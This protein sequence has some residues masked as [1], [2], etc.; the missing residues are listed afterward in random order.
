MPD[1]SYNTN[2]DTWSASATTDFFAFKGEGGMTISQSFGDVSGAI[3]KYDLEDAIVFQLTKDTINNRINNTT[4]QA[5]FTD[6][7]VSLS[8]ADIS[9]TGME[10]VGMGSRFKKIYKD[11]V[12][13][14]QDYFGIVPSAWDIPN[15]SLLFN[16]PTSTLIY[17]R[18]NEA[19]KLGELK[20]DGFKAL[21]QNS[22]TTTC[23]LRVD[24]LLKNFENAYKTN[25]FG[26]KNSTI[27][28]RR[29][30]F[31]VDDLIYFKDGITVRFD[32]NLFD[33]SSNVAIAN[34]TVDYINSVVNTTYGGLGSDTS[35]V[36]GAGMASTTTTTTIGDFTT[37]SNITTTTLTKTYKAPLVIRI[38]A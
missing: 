15:I 34:N 22:T 24:D 18:T 21:I 19:G 9:G 12:G 30:Q 31:C 14:V 23:N 10:V 20:T 25:V 5:S 32:V 28:N 17:N 33:N 6:N 7:T 26:N 16:V 27:P 38:V 8:Y 11:F 4:K 35:N 37:T 13:E 3:R 36:N 2:V 1:A 29:T